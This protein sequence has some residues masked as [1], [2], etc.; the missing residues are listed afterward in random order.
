MLIPILVLIAIIILLGG[1]GVFLHWLW[2]AA[3]V[4]L[5]IWLI[6]FFLRTAEGSGRRWYRW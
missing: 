4:A 5:I 2:I 6:G 1:G 3:I